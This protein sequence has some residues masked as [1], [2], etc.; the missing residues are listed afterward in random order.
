MRCLRVERVTFWVQDSEIQVKNTEI[1]I[2][3]LDSQGISTYLGVCRWSHKFIISMF[4]HLLRS[5]S[6]VGCTTA[7]I[8]D[9]F[10]IF[11]ILEIG[12]CSPSRNTT[13]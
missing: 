13:T 9:V 11:Y 4:L 6:K 3:S 7:Y 12:I 8:Y 10:G 5:E 1:L 2:L